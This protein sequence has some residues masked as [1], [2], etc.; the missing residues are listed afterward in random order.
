MGVLKTHD[1]VLLLKECA[2]YEKDF[3]NWRG[4]CEKLAEYYAPTRYPE[5][6]A[7]PEYTKETAKEALKLA[8]EMLEFVKKKLI[9]YT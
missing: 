1:L 8:E 5:V 9:R 2:K 3:Q 7:L 6:L 4:V